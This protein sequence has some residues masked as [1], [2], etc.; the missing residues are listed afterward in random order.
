MEGIITTA[1]HAPIPGG[2]AG[3]GDASPGYGGASPLGRRA[4]S[5]F[6]G[7]ADLVAIANR[8]LDRYQS[9][10]DELHRQCAEH[11]SGP[12]SWFDSWAGSDASATICQTAA[13]LQENHDAARVV[14]N[15]PHAT[16][17]QIRRVFN[18]IP[19]E[20]DVADLR[21]QVEATSAGSALAEGWRE[22]T[23][24]PGEAA[25]FALDTAGSVGLGIL[26]NFPWW[27]WAGGALYLAVAVGGLFGR[28]RA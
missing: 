7:S 12:Q 9:H 2:F 20:V 1:G 4:F 27:V 22:T 10:I 13:T 23:E 6:A 21:A 16:D 11:S 15:D 18:L 8:G 5:G 24:L 25:G 14:V 28:R 19:N 3:F 26:K 17:D